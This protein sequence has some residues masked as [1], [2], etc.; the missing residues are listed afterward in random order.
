MWKLK[1]L[2]CGVGLQV[3]VQDCLA[4]KA[5]LVA[6]LPLSLL[7]AALIPWQYLGI[8]VNWF[9]CIMLGRVGKSCQ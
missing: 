2:L 9:E 3:C 1:L 6:S 4:S 7:L 5:E 8:G